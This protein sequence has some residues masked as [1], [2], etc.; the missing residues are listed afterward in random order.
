MRSKTSQTVIAMKRVLRIQRM[1]ANSTPSR[2]GR[3]V[4]ASRSCVRCRIVDVENLTLTVSLH[5]NENCNWLTFYCASNLRGSL[6]KGLNKQIMLSETQFLY[7]SRSLSWWS[8]LSCMPQESRVASGARPALGV[9]ARKKTKGDDQYNNAFNI[10]WQNDR[11]VMPCPARASSA[12]TTHD[13]W[14]SLMHA[15]IGCEEFLFLD[16]NMYRCIDV[17]LPKYRFCEVDWSID[18]NPSQFSHCWCVDSYPCVIYHFPH[19][20]Q[21]K[22]NTRFSRS[23]ANKSLV[24]GNWK[25]WIK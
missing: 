14:C 16:S 18:R 12:H 19:E 13:L 25:P 22:F 21:F 24:T 8:S 15:T 9:A 10:S 2:E 23:E 5:M 6:R 4:S 3:C 7:E 1:D 17:G 20:S 11:N